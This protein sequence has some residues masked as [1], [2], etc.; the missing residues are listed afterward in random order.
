MSNL[1]KDYK[2]YNLNLNYSMYFNE[3]NFMYFKLQYY[4]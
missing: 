2:L 3:F 4:I 1:G